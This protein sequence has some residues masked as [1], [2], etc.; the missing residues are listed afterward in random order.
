M[1][2]DYNDVV[3]LVGRHLHTHMYSEREGDNGS[4]NAAFLL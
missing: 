3:E 1:A 2:H 4:N